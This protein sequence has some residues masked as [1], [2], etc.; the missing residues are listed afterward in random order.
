MLKQMT[1][2]G[3]SNSQIAQ[4]LGRT[5]GAISFQKNAMKLTPGKKKVWSEWTVEELSHLNRMVKEDGI[6]LHEAAKKF[7]RS[8]ADVSLAF[9][10]GAKA[11][12]QERKGVRPTSEKSRKGVRPTEATPRDNAKEMTRLVR[13][14]ARA[15]GQRIT[16][17]MFFVENI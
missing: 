6:S 7:G 15:N 16:M 17:A 8:L 10:G 13:Q 14:I 5:V 11:L 1:K 12:P 9:V 3:K 2:D 4:A